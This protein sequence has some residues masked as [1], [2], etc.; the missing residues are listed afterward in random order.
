MYTFQIVRVVT[1]M[2]YSIIA[3]I[4]IRERAHKPFNIVYYEYTRSND[5]IVF[6]QPDHLVGSELGDPSTSSWRASSYKVHGSSDYLMQISFDNSELTINQ[7]TEGVKN[8]YFSFCGLPS[9]GMSL[10]SQGANGNLYAVTIYR[11]P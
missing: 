8:Y 3:P 1:L 9:D 7:A 2:T 10:F 11:E 4:F 5:D 6:S